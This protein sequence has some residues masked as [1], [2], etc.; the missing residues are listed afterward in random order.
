MTTSKDPKKIVDTNR[1]LVTNLGTFLKPLNSEYGKVIPGWGTTKL[2]GAF[3]SLF[4]LFLI[5]L[6]E[7]YNSSVLLEEVRIS[8]ESRSILKK[9]I[10]SFIID[11]RIYFS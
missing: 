1:Y 7:I 9:I 6:I 8:W 10:H 5:I 3:M 4:L 2:I 11:L